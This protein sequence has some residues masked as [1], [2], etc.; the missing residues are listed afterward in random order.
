[1]QPINKARRRL[2][3]WMSA[4]GG[5]FAI[6]EAKAHHTDTHFADKSDH[7][8]VPVQQGGSRLPV[9]HSVLGGRD[10]PHA[11]RQ[12]RGRRRLFRSGHPPAR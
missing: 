1:M 7:Q 2:L 12:H 9:A 8:I 4:A 3:Q 10:D 6:N 5:L 11:R